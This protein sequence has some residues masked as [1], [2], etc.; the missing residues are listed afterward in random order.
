MPHNTYSDM[1]K[2]PKDSVRDSSESHISGIAAS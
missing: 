1:P 2:K